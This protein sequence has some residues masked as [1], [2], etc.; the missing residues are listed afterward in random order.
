[1][2]DFTPILMFVTLFLMLFLGVPIA[3]SLSFTGIVFAFFLWGFDSTSLLASA[4]WGVM[5]NFTLIAIP[6]FIFMSVLLEKSNI[7][8]DLYETFYK[9]SG[10]LRGGLII[11]TIV[12][13]AILG[14]VSGVVAAGVIG[15]GLIAFPLMKKY[16]YQENLSLG[17]IMASGTLGQLIP[18][19]LNMI[20]YGAITGVSVSQL[21]AGG[22]SAGIFLT[23]L[24]IIYIFIRTLIN[25]D[26]APALA[27]ENRATW[28]EKI[29]SLKAV[30]LPMLLII[31]VLGAIFSG[32]ATPT[33][34][35]AVGVMGTL[36]LCSLTKRINIKS[37]LSS[38]KETIKMSTMVGWIL[39]GASCFSS[40][41][42]GIGGN[43][44][45]ADI[46]NAAPGGKWGVLILSVLFI[47][48]LGMFLET[49]A[50]I[51]L[52]AP[53]I[54]PLIASYGFDPLWWGIV[55]MLILQMAFLTPPFG[56]AIFY[57][58]SAVPKDVPI[59]RIY[60]STIPFIL[61]QLLAAIIFI[62]FPALALWLPKLLQ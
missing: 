62:L 18:P 47:I 55:F 56:F 5:N 3:F 37:L 41:F 4:A 54:S 6:L 31:I 21:F 9:W 45:V 26:I 42:S 15:L 29:S 2:L 49:V 53:I 11:A 39:I 57:L 59:E 10:G 13:G 48:F 28:E 1:M 16:K 17:S 7:I 25:K 20:V 8:A 19:S 58:K 60:K 34:G 44:M 14:A 35:G 36:V 46:A 51:M 24:F 33:E 61:I 23:I 12:V 27:K 43:R 30:F 32:A 40:V 50:L 38:L 22:L 52:A